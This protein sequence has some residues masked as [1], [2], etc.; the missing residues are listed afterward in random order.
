MALVMQGGFL[1]DST[2]ALAVTTDQ[3]NAVI[4]GGFLRDPEGRLVVSG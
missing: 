3:T 4:W 2:G 1:V